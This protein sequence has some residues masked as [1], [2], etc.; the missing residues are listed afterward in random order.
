M[1]AQIKQWFGAVGWFFQH[2]GGCFRQ[3][4][5]HLTFV[6]LAVLDYKPRLVKMLGSGVGRGGR[7]AVPP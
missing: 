1:N 2:L 5:D 3:G 7:G 4:S 6:H